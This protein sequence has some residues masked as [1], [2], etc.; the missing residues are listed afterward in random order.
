MEKLS[1]FFQEN[2]QYGGIIPALFGL[3][4]LYGAFYSLDKMIE[5]DG[6][7]HANIISRTYNL[8]GY[9]AAKFICAAI[10]VFLILLGVVWYFLY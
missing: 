3:Y 2:P 9:K 5:G 10:G 8:F 6:L 7:N 4:F 1:A